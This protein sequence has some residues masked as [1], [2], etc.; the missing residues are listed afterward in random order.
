MINDN[1]KDEPKL[2]EDLSGKKAYVVWD[3]DDSVEQ[4]VYKNSNKLIPDFIARSKQ[5]ISNIYTFITFW[6][7]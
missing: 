4:F 6:K 7:K 3:N 2:S 1:K 5:I